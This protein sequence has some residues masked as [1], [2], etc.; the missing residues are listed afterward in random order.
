MIRLMNDYQRKT[1]ED[2]KPKIRD[3]N[4]WSIKWF[5]FPFNRNL[6]LTT[7]QKLK[8][9]TWGFF[10]GLVDA[11]KKPKSQHNISIIIT[12]YIFFFGNKTTQ[13]YNRDEKIYQTSWLVWAD[14][15][16]GSSLPR[17]VVNPLVPSGILGPGGRFETSTGWW[18]W[19][20]WED[21]EADGAVPCPVAKLQKWVST[22]QFQIT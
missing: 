6:P 10:R 7:T 1:K 15:V 18:L 4:K 9:Q 16:G 13:W 20:R 22:F 11:K 17:P 21:D 2:G 14:M 8:Y 19:L 12:T 3:S 5:T